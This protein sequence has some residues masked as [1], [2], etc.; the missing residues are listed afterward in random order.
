M[1]GSEPAPDR[2][3]IQPGQVGQPV[4]AR[5]LEQRSDIAEVGPDCVRRQAALRRQM[6]FERSQLP[7]NAA[8]QRLLHRPSVSHPPP[9]GV[10]ATRARA[11]RPGQPLSRQ[12]AGQRPAPGTRK[13]AST[14]P[15]PPAGRDYSGQRPAPGTR[16]P[17]S[18]A[19][20][21]PA[22]RDYS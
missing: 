20:P 13:P 5:M 10:Q 7:R 9:G 21:P 8:G 14:A 4:L 1:L 11:T 18:T 12:P 6:S 16:K 22:G 15:P 3:D 19:P 2:A 17:A